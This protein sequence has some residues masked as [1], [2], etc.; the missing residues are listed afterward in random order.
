MAPPDNTVTAPTQISQLKQ[1]LA[2]AASVCFVKF[3][4][5]GD[6]RQLLH[7][8]CRTVDQLLQQLWQQ[9][10]LNQQDIALIAVGGYGRGELHPHSDIDLLLLSKK[11]LKQCQQEAIGQFITLLWDIKLD[12]G[13]SVRTLTDT[14]AL[15]KEDITVATNLM[16]SRLL[17]GCDLLYQQLLTAIE[18]PNFW[19]SSEFYLAKREEQVSRHQS[20][21]AFDLEPNIKTCPGGLRDIQT[22][23]WIAKR[24]FK[25]MLVEQLVTHGFLSEEE[26]AELFCCQDFLWR[27]RFALHQVAGRGEDK[28]LFN[29]QADVALALGYC[30]KDQ[31]AVEQ[32]MKQYYQTVRQVGELCDM[33]LQLFKRA[34]LGKIKDL[35]VFDIDSHYQRRDR[36]L[37]AKSDH[38]FDQPEQLILLY[39]NVANEPEITGIYAPTLRL[40]RRARNGLDQPLSTLEPCRRAFMELLKHP[41]GIKAF[42]MMHK[43]GILGSYL[44]AWQ[45]ITGQ[46]QFDLFHAYTVDEHTHRLLLNIGRFSMPEHKT[47]FPLCSVLIKTIAKKGLL[48]LAGIFHDIGKG[49]GG[50]H[51]KLGRQDALDFGK[52]HN[53][54]QHDSNLVAWLVENHLLMSITAQRRDIHDIDVINTF[55]EKVRDETHLAYLYCLTVADICATNNNLWN[56]WKGSLLRELY[57]YTLRALRRGKVTE[58]DAD[59]RINEY[60]AKALQLIANNVNCAASTEQITDLWETFQ[61]DYFLRHSPKLLAGH[62]EKIFSTTVKKP[63]LIS[64]INYNNQ[65]S[66][67]LFIY[68]PDKPHLFTT[69]MRV[70]G[71][72][73]VQINDAFIMVSDKGFALDTFTISEFDGSAIIDTRRINSIVQTLSKRLASEN[74]KIRTPRRISRQVQHFHVPTQVNFIQNQPTDTTAFELVARDIPGLLANLGDVFYKNKILLLSAKI[75]T[76]GERVEDFFIISTTQGTA[77]TLEQQDSLQHALIKAIEKLNQ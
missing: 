40:L 30:D 33:L 71:S 63:P 10:D 43:H 23:G 47:E 39:L 50:D 73:N 55:A 2:D 64:L 11:P 77:L 14:I 59:G 60:K 3:Q 52:S 38:I 42:S 70:L 27:L 19:P 41:N 29:Y 4:D 34:F 18:K 46:M 69:V 54:N 24:H 31:L 25:T 21:N 9:F 74:V 65:S 32:M 58:V 7:S 12:I 36:F 5:Q 8:R 13:H 53:L 6:I 1:H 67:E 62:C 28:L 68:T 51:S 56:S 49:R 16:E 75:T 45:N 17:G 76:I 44:P 57:F 37:E 22:I 72:K 20:N 15:G 66:S 48:V 35:Q 61:P 26:L